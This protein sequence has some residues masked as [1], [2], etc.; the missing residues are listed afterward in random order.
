MVPD[1]VPFAVLL[2][3]DGAFAGAE[4]EA[5]LAGSAGRKGSKTLWRRTCAMDT[6]GMSRRD[7]TVGSF[8]LSNIEYVVIMFSVYSKVP[9]VFVF[10]QALT[11]L[12]WPLLANF[13]KYPKSGDLHS[14]VD[15]QHISV[16][17]MPCQT[18][19]FLYSVIGFY[20]DLGNDS[21]QVT[22][23]A[24]QRQTSPDSEFPLC[25]LKLAYWMTQK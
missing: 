3:G 11:Q 14:L 20:R 7:S 6:E 2:D 16:V 25:L 17:N 23:A 9:S 21:S 19:F 10:Y 12:S 22:N 5:G 13:P 8:R 4:E 15:C 1:G 18:A 24:T